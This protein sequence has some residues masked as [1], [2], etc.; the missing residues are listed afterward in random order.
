MNLIFHLLLAHF[1]A[2]YP[3]QPGELVKK[4]YESVLGILMHTL[5]HLSVIIALTF[6]FLSDMRVAVGV[7]IIF[8][9]HNLID[10]TKIELEKRYPHLNRFTLYIGDQLIHLAIIFPVAFLIIGKA[11][12]GMAGGWFDLYSER[13]LV[14]ILLSLT[15]ATYFLDVTRWTYSNSKKKKTYKRDYSFMCKNALAVILI[16]VG[17]CLFFR[18]KH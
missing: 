1:L 18:I 10:F 16:F 14:I 9:T 3:F 13:R 15:L 5:I 4:K 12:A 11:K 17:L 7:V 6:P 8:I 2:D